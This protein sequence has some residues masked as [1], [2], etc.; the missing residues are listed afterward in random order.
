MPRADCGAAVSIE[1]WLLF[2]PV[3][4]TMTGELSCISR[5][6]RFRHRITTL[7]FA[8][9]SSCFRTVF[10]IVG[11]LLSACSSFARVEE[12]DFDMTER[13]LGGRGAAGLGL[14]VKRVDVGRRVAM[15]GNVKAARAVDERHEE[16][17]ME[18]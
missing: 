10:W 15:V 5:S 6:E 1:T 12:P 13:D 18:H 8:S 17:R 11:T 7:I 3:E 4:V 14:L 16:D 2:A 9:G